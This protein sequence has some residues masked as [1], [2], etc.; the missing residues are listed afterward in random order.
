MLL[1][2]DGTQPE[3]AREAAAKSRAACQQLRDREQS[4]SSTDPIRYSGI[5]LLEV[6]ADVLE[7]VG[8]PHQ[9]VRVL[10]RQLLTLEPRMLVQREE[11]VPVAKL[12]SSLPN[13]W[14]P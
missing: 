14:S 12:S 7:D 10:V 6:L 2:S 11:R 8:R 13:P 4:L 3:E 9:H 1:A 5:R